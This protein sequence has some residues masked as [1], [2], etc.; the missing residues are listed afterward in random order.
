MSIEVPVFF[1]F[2]ASALCYVTMLF[3]ILRVDE[4]L[5]AERWMAGF[6]LW[7]LLVA[8]ALAMNGSNVN[9]LKIAPGLWLALISLGGMVLLGALSFRYLEL[10]QAGWWPLAYP[11]MAAIL[12]WVALRDSSTFGSINPTWRA[13]L[14]QHG[15]WLP[16]ATAL[17]W[18]A[19][20]LALLAITFNAVA[21]A[22]Q[23][24]H[25]NRRLWWLLALLSILGGEATAMWGASTL[26]VIGQALRVA[27]VA[28]ATYA[29]ISHDLIDI[30][31]IVRDMI[32]NILFALVMAAFLL[33]GIGAGIFLLNRLPGTQGQLALGALVIILAL[34][35]QRMRPALSGLVQRVV[36][37]AGYDT[38]QIAGNY[39]RQAAEILDVHQL[40]ITVGLTF[41][42]AVQSSRT[43]LIL[44]SPAPDYMINAEV[45]I[46]AG[47]MPTTPNLFSARSPLLTALAHTRQTLTQ[48]AID[49]GPEF[50]AMPA[51]DR[52]WLHQLG[53]DI[54]VPVFDGS[55]LSAIL[56]V[57]AR[58]NRDA[59]RSRELELLS[60]IADQTSV[61]LK[62]ARLVTNLR[63]LNE[64]MR[65][66]NEEM[67]VLNKSLADGNERLRQMDKVK[68]DFINIASHELRTPLTKIRGYTDILDA[69]SSHGSI[70]KAQ[71]APILS[72]LVRA[73]DRLEEV[74]GQMLDVSQLDVEAL[75]LNFVDTT[76]DAIIKLAI[77]PLA[78][79]ARERHQTIAYPGAPDLPP[80]KGDFQRLV[81]ALRQVVGNAIKF[82]PDGGT[83]TIDADYLPANADRARPEAVE[84]VVSDTGVGIE[85]EYHELIF[86]KFFRVGSASVHSTGH[87][88]F[89]GAG[90]GLG[91]TIA[92]GVIKGHGGQIWVESPGHDKDRRPGSRFHIVLPLEPTPAN[93]QQASPASAAR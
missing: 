47:K 52:E 59:Y 46:G 80:L 27:G 75:Q 12:I 17:L 71:I 22:R 78:L 5:G 73:S 14:A 48:Y 54:Y 79:A 57:G 55:T 16:W 63:T 1:A 58:L 85:P 33:V 93:G 32:G 83:I 20:G 72:Q 4:P 86:E 18:G 36:L 90:P 69:I 9:V 53:I 70:D 21:E 88:K 87:T 3:F 91:L 67:S 81:Q 64:E 66:L 13:A 74:I 30:R 76:A 61:A 84:I 11:P 43:A 50:K 2:V 23:P 42:E 38:A 29:I 77:E 28:L 10:P 39:S 45:L 40:A 60:A 34:T 6:T 15:A 37:A 92:R 19:L 7:S 82:T 68:S 41:S 44:L 51:A 62:N 65:G 8:A 35:Y 24:L 25:A 49:Y 89:M 26:D 31:G 56:A